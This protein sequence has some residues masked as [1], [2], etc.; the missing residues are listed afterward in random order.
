MYDKYKR[1]VQICKII[2]ILEISKI[3]N[4]LCYQLILYFRLFVIYEK[5]LNINTLGISYSLIS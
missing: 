5:Y 3:K 2:N 4:I 1:M